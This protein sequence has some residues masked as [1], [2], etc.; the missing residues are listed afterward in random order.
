MEGGQEG[1]SLPFRPLANEG[2]RAGGTASFSISRERGRMEVGGTASS[3]ISCG[4]ERRGVPL[5]FQSLVL[6]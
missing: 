2:K 4:G 3:S 1:G 5:R 6:L